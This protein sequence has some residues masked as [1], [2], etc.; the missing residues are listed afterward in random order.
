MVVKE[1]GLKGAWVMGIKRREEQV[2]LHSIKDNVYF[3]MSYYIFFSD[4]KERCSKSSNLKR[5]AIRRRKC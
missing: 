1:D 4:P 3:M 5:Q 2:L